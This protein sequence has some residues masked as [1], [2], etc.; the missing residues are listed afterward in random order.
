VNPYVSNMR[1]GYK[2]V[3]QGLYAVAQR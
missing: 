2:A 1:E 3:L